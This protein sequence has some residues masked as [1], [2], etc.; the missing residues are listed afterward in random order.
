MDEESNFQVIN[1]E[2]KIWKKNCPFLYDVVVTHALEWP[3]LT[4]EWLPE[5]MV[6]EENHRVVH[7]LV[8]GTHCG[9]GAQNALLLANVTLPLA[10]AGWDD[11]K[12]D[13]NSKI[14][15]CASVL[16][17]KYF[18]FF[19]PSTNRSFPSASCILSLPPFHFGI[20]VVQP[21][22]VMANPPAL[23][24]SNVSPT[25]EMSIE[26]VTCLKIPN[27]SQRLVRP[28][29][30]VCTTRTKKKLLKTVGSLVNARGMGKKDTVYVGHPSKLDVWCPPPTTAPF[31]SG[32]PP[33]QP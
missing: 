22:K 28:A 23:T 32:T 19:F 30:F 7:N 29:T 26:P 33:A 25:P 18:H 12:V 13:A 9:E 4:C 16:L 5:P 21:T 27:S 1:E 11:V 20:V 6:D 31:V 14:E 17:K 15:C 10:S 24:L 3:S 2:F 8:L